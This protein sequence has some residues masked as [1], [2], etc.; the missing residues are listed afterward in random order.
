VGF[1][2]EIGLVQLFTFSFELG[3]LH[4][5]MINY[6]KNG[7]KMQKYSKK[8]TLDTSATKLLEILISEDFENDKNVKANGT[9]KSEYKLISK[10]DSEMEYS[11]ISTDYERTKIGGINKSKT[12][13]TH[14]NYK[15]N[16]TAKTCKWT[17]KHPMGKKIMVSGSLN[18]VDSGDKCELDNNMSIEIKI[19]FIGG[20][21]EKKI[22]KEIKSGWPK[23]EALVNEYVKK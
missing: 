20:T 18:V 13:E 4:W 16:L 14:Y 19:P 6:F 23:Y 9:L 5:L 7:D 17:M 15:W 21:I 22:L 1:I 3:R 12:E 8:I 2:Y 11:S 10:S